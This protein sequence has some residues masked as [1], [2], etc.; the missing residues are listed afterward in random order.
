ME[1]TARRTIPRRN[2]TSNRRKSKP[3]YNYKIFKKIFRQLIVSALILICILSVKNIDTPF[4][5]QISTRINNFLGNN[6]DYGKVSKSIADFIAKANGGG[7]ASLLKKESEKQVDSAKNAFKSNIEEKS[8]VS[9]ESTISLEQNNKPIQANKDMDEVK[10][11][12]PVISSLN[13]TEI[14]YKGVESYF[15]MG[16]PVKGTTSSGFGLRTNPI[17][18]KEEFHPGI[19]IKA[20][21]GTAI[22]AVISG[23]VIE[24]RK[25]T[26]FGN[27][28]RVQSEKDVMTVFAHCDRLLVKKGQKVSKGQKIA[29]VG[30]TGMSL[31]AHLHF[32]IWRAGR[33]L[34]PARFFTEYSS[35][36]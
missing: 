19:D 34:D 30:N 2:I 21:R 12:L 3:I 10:I 17:T 23:E 15:K 24:A 14:D 20:N 5:K 22:Y 25:G 28:I 18:K 4:T 13:S 31:G 11:A 26:T 8:S 32:E 16:L 33:P 6:L 27:F 7:I 29:E 9:A 36:K 35:K 1:E